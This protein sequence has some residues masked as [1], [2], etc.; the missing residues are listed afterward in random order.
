MTVA[1]FAAPFFVPPEAMTVIKGPYPAPAGAAAD[2]YNGKPR[3]G[4]AGA[5][6]ASISAA[7]GRVN[8]KN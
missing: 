8:E 4:R 3:T 7:M 5:A 6:D 1:A 2:D